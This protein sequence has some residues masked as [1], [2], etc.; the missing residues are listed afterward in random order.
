M[1]SDLANTGLSGALLRQ[2]KVKGE[3]QRGV[4][5][6]RLLFIP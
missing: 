5:I 6:K 1:R 2:F 3:L 4:F